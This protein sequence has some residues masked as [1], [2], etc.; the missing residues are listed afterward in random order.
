MKIHDLQS[1]KPARTVNCWRGITPSHH[2]LIALLIGVLALLATPRIRA[3]THTWTGAAGDGLWSTAGNWSGNSKPAFGE[4]NVRIVFPAAGTASSTMDIAGLV[5][6]EFLVTRPTNTT[7]TLN[8]TAGMK[9]T[10]EARP[11]FTN[12]HVVGGVLAVLPA[13]EFVLSNDCQIR[14][15]GYTQCQTIMGWESCSTHE[16]GGVVLSNRLSGP[17]GL[18]I[19]GYGAVMM[20]GPQGNTYAGLT[21]VAP[22]LRLQL[23]KASGNAVPAALRTDT[24]FI[25]GFSPPQ[26]PSRF[27]RGVVDLLDD[28]QLSNTGAIT[29]NG[30]I[31]ATNRIETLGPLTMTHGYVYAPGSALTLNGTVTVLF[32]DLPQDL[33]ALQPSYLDAGTLALGT[34]AMGRPLRY[35]DIRTNALLEVAAN[36]TGAAAVGLDKFGPGYLVL[37]GTNTFDGD[38]IVDDGVLEL[39]DGGWGLGTTNGDT[40]VNTGGKLVLGSNDPWPGTN[41]VVQEYFRLNGGELNAVTAGTHEL[42]SPLVLETNSILSGGGW[43]LSGPISGAGGLHLDH[44]RGRFTGNQTN[45]YAGVTLVDDSEFDLARAIGCTVIPSSL[46]V[47]GSG[48]FST[49][50]VLTTN[51]IADG[52]TVHLARRGYLYLSNTFETITTLEL[53]AGTVQGPG[54]L[55]VISNVVALPGAFNEANQIFARLHLKSGGSHSIQV[56]DVPNRYP[57]LEI[58]GPLTSDAGIGFTKTGPG[59]VELSGANT[60]SGAVVVNA[61]LVLAESTQAFGAGGGSVG[62]HINA[63]GT[64]RLGDD[65]SI[66]NEPLAFAGGTLL[67]GT[68]THR[69]G[70]IVNWQTNSWLAV[71]NAFSS[72]E[73]PGV[74]SGAASLHK[75][76]PGLFQLTGSGANTFSGTLYLDEGETWL[77]KTNV[78]ALPSNVVIGTATNPAT[79]RLFGNS[80]IAG[81]G[82]VAA[83]HPSS[84]FDVQGFLQTIG[85]FTGDGLINIGGGLLAI[86][87]DGLGS[88]FAG[89]SLNGG[90][91]FQ[92]LGSGIFTLSGNSAGFT[93]GT[94]VNAGTLVVSGNLANSLVTVAAGGTL[95][96]GG[97]VGQVNNSGLASPGLSPGRL[98]T[99]H[100]TNNATSTL[101][102]ELNGV[103]AGTTHDQVDTAGTVK[104]AGALQLVR[105]SNTPPGSAFTII[106]ND[107]ADAVLGTFTGLAQ[108]AQ[109]T[110]GGAKFQISYT[111]G[112][113]NDVVL[114]QVATATNAL[115]RG[116][117]RLGN[118]TMQLGASGSPGFDYTVLANTNLNTTNWL[119]LG[120]VTPA[121]NGAMNFTDLAATN[122]PARFYRFVIP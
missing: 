43:N 78:L 89:G 37:H 40:R 30:L 19:E 90:G 63:G 85:T 14:L 60:F 35:F 115:L 17:G 15:D 56:Q 38:V 22:H 106:K 91:T 2:I 102:I 58:T 25:A 4:L 36:I 76:G 5:V 72:L 119:T 3:G 120:T 11:G 18:L 41:L 75:T 64:V 107:G 61:G 67:V 10:L 81:A 62:V 88:G 59:A 47:T 9:V 44:A 98:T 45:T 66:A 1:L 84:I 83:P 69:W 34:I 108:G 48:I 92:K 54:T 23:N 53:A 97:T 77:A 116:V 82:Y 50:S 70:G 110:N 79:L 49:L 93:G 65:L 101:V 33:N 122:H 103:V 121:G 28:H 112:D 105:G 24:E 16:F 68:G 26:F 87:G 51:Q 118:G 100:F 29:N 104:L 80:Q 8:G 96:G 86:G 94:I 39:A 95:A 73:L 42:L 109:I 20:A 32:E 21:H 114:T 55:A 13:L 52:V 31:R 111:G 57:D 71:T 27:Y 74:V 46:I 12:V 113:G 7:H 99:K 117:T 6:N